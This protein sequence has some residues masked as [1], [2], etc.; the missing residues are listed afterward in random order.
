MKPNTPHHS[1]SVQ[2]FCSEITTPNIPR[3]AP[4]AAT[5]IETLKLMKTKSILLKL[6]L[7]LC[8]AFVSTT[9]FGQNNVWTNPVVVG[10]NGNN[11]G[12][13]TNYTGPFVS[14]GLGS[15][16]VLEFNGGVPGP[17][18]VY[19][20]DGI[21][22][23]SGNLVGGSSGANGVTVLLDATQTSPVQISSTASPV[24]ANM[25]FNTFTVNAGAGQ[26][27]LGDNSASVLSAVG[28]PSGATHDY[29]NL[30]AN[31]VIICP[32]VVW[33]NG[34]A[35]A[36]TFAFD[37][38]TG[39]PGS[40]FGDYGITNSLKS[41][42]GGSI[43]LQFLSSGVITWNGTA[44]F[45]YAPANLP[46]N[47]TI[48]TPV[49]LEFGTTL[50]LKTN[51]L[52]TTQAIQNNNTGGFG[53]CPL[54]Y[55]AGNN[56]AQTLS[57]V[58][59]GS[60]PSILI[61]VKSGTL[62]LSGA[63]IYTG[64]ITNSGGEL[65]AG[66]A[67]N[68]GVS[69]PFG[70]CGKIHL[71]GGTLGWS[72]ANSFDYSSRFDTV[73]GQVYNFD[74]GLAT[75]TLGTS[76][77]SSGATLTKSGN[78]TIILG[79]ACSYNGATTVS[80]GEL[81][82]QGAMTGT[83]N[84]TV[85][86][87]ATLGAYANGTQIQPTTLA[88]GTTSGVNLEFNTVNSTATAIIAAGGL[89]A[90]S[91]NLV[92]INIKSGT[93]TVGQSYPL[94]TWGGVAPAPATQLGILNGYIGNIST[95]G[96]KIQLNIT[97]TAYTWTGNNNNSWDTTTANNWQQNG[98][99]VVFANGFPTLFDDS[100]VNNLNVTNSGVVLPSALTVN[101]NTNAY[102]I[103]SSP[104][105]FIGGTTGL[106]KQGT[107]SLS[108]NGGA[109]TNTGITTISGGTVIVGAL[110]N[111][112]SASDIGA[113][114]SNAVNLVLD[115]GTLRYTNSTVQI[116]RLFSVTTA[117]GV[118][119]ASG[120][121]PLQF[122]N[123]ASIAAPGSGTR[124]VI[125]T[126]SAAT[127]NT[128]AVKIVDSTGGATSLQKG[129]VGGT[130]GE[131]DLTGNNTYSGV[132]TI[133]NGVL[134]IGQ[135]TATGSLGTGNTT[136]NGSLIFNRTNSLTYGGVISGSGT[137]VVQTGTVTLTGNNTYNN[138]GTLGSTTISNGATLNVG[139]GGAGASLAL[140]GSISN[141]GLLVFNSSTPITIRGFPS[142]I[143]GTGNIEAK[144]TGLVNATGYVNTWTGWLLI[145][146]G[147]TFQPTIGNESQLVCSA[148]TN[149]GTLLVE[150]Q[151]NGVFIYSNN[152]T[153]TGKLVMDAN[154]QNSGDCTFIGTNTY[155]GGTI[156][157]DNQL[158]FG[159]GVTPGAGSFLGNVNFTNSATGQN[160]YRALVFNRP[161]SFTFPGNI[162]GTN[163]GAAGNRGRV[164]QRGTG[165]LTLTV[166]NTYI[167]GTIV[168]NGMLQVGNGGTTGSIG[169][170]TLDVT[171][172]LVFNRSDAVTFS[173]GINGTGMVAQ[174]GSGTLTLSGA[175]NLWN[176]NGNDASYTAGTLAASNG[177]LVVT[178]GS[179]NGNLNVSGGTF[180]GGVASTVETLAVSNN[181]TITSG[182]VEVTVNKSLSPGQSNCVYLV[183]TNLTAAGATWTLKLVNYGPAFV[184]GDRFY[185]FG[186]ADGTHKGLSS[187]G[188]VTVTAPGV[189]SWD[190]S[191]LG[192]DGSVA[193]LT[194]AT[195]PPQITAVRSG[196][197]L[198]L[199]WPAAWTGVHLQ[200]QTNTL[201]RGL[202][203][204]WVTIAGS[205]AGNTYSTSF[206]N[207]NVFY[208]LAP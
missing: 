91:T 165:V 82:F 85:N 102:Q 34:G 169:N 45:N 37:D 13:H 201:T 167:D 33:Q 152:I 194:V 147:A 133:N 110:A 32:N 115:G 108:L 81:L 59:G 151:D 196:A 199:S 78:G 73:A 164:L 166:A 192:V 116:D 48:A 46:P 130:G 70:V 132:T 161:D 90:Q 159:D 154:N 190:T 15:G 186:N 178:G 38:P 22:H 86:N 168:S 127:N 10:P 109:N 171:T 5:G 137:V 93:F 119:E 44:G 181:M 120:V 74:S 185:L 3:Q 92:T 97:G 87:G 76:L 35:A 135:G 208:R 57:G 19:Q 31:P 6:A 141:N 62:T 180:D 128:M 80:A 206:G 2:K 8:C 39:V 198:N 113:S 121:G 54:I 1:P 111:G 103:T 125:L 96:N 202:T 36:M 114:S 148:I 49:L 106:N 94:F 11:I 41:S 95:N 160:N 53:P 66:G 187:V 126:G 205:D 61:Q 51:N 89:S 7:I 28:R 26:F 101:N 179:V 184:P 21:D 118:I 182:T 200:S 77:A 191:Q 47:G 122:T 20:N 75:V 50:I 195:A 158:V 134:R 175:V 112:G 23:A 99:P 124:T 52:L 172:T 153:G 193:V 136:D 162:T 143:S 43:S 188:T 174:A 150:R 84:I 142:T 56:T 140:F 60:S 71:L 123:T 146:A 27:T 55:D 12:V 170:G 72:L 67:E 105:N 197:N 68:A 173:G 100:T 131:W 138:G 98:G 18:V 4:A 58:I 42:N 40:G 17:M 163:N 149:N 155:T 177:T 30:S 144:G 14:G 107:N 65:I 129:G 145:D 183:A 88:L 83:G 203:T 189:T 176:T 9:V 69:G 64:D 29:Q 117:G 79:G 63:N 139:S 104:G 207:T 25:G 156:I 24:G 157:A 16:T 204:N